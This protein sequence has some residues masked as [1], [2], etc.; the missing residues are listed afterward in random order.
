LRIAL[1]STRNEQI[2]TSWEAVL[3]ESVGKD[4]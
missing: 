1:I 2:K 3:L 4:G